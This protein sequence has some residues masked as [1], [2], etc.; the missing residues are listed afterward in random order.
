MDARDRQL[1]EE[2]D[3]KVDLILV[4]RFPSIEVRFAE[5]KTQFSSHAKVWGAVAGF[6]A[7]TIAGPLVLVL[8]NR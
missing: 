4:E 1:L 7:S 6:V 8:L 3:R 5:L 2:L